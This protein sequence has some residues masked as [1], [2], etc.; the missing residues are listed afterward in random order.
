MI[1]STY[2][3]CAVISEVQDLIV[4]VRRV[5]FFNACPVFSFS[6]LLSACFCGVVQ[7]MNWYLKIR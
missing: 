7:Q 3:V 4:L 5:M 6:F 1:N 2:Y